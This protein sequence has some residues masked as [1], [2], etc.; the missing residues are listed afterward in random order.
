LSENEIRKLQSTFL[1]KLN[2]PAIVVIA[3]LLL[4][5]IAMGVTRA[6][7]IYLPLTGTSDAIF[8]AVSGVIYA[9][10]GLILAIFFFITA[11]KLRNFL[12]EK[13]E[14]WSIPRERLRKVPILHL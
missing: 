3:F 4:S 13:A 14:R 12:N 6:L 9:L 8:S 5:E 2:T 11:H 7:Q 1:G 10:T